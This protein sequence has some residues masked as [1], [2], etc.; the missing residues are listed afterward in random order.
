M[1][2][3][4]YYGPR[5]LRIEEVPEPGSPGATD[6]LVRV[7]MAAICGTDSSEWAHGPILAQPPVTLGHEFTGTVVA[8]GAEVTSF[9]RGDRVVSGS[10]ISCG[11]CAWCKEGRTNLCASYKTLGLHVDG[12][13]ADL[14]MVPATVCVTVPE[15]TSDVAA[16]MAQPFAVALHGLRRAKVSAGR[17][18]VVLGVGGIGGFLVAGAKARGAKQVIAV[19]IDDE[20]L[21]LAEKLGAT[22]TVNPLRQDPLAQVLE[23][24]DGAGIQSVVE[25]TGVGGNPSLAIAM[26]QKGGSVLMLGLQSRPVEIDLL[27]VSV[28]EL[29]VLGTLAHVCEEDIP[30]ALQVLSSSDLSAL[31][32]DSV[33]GLEELL[34]QGIKPLAERRAKGKIVVDVA[35][36]AAKRESR[37]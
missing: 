35:G 37:G 28:R 23:V 22:M 27:A 19:D 12:G 15:A 8:V 29:D 24:T 33:I 4:R 2:A 16:A 20:K 5:E 13:L 18:V 10:G 32:L 36:R 17:S 3:A 21:E 9:R 26:A 30:E 11:Q 31:M 14:V 25:A 1:R 6:L 34:E 7:S